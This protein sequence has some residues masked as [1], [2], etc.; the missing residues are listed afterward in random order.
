MS[1]PQ[2]RNHM[3]S[4]ISF[5]VKEVPTKQN[6]L[7]GIVEGTVSDG[8]ETITDFGV[9]DATSSNST[10]PGDILDKAKENVTDILLQREQ[11]VAPTPAQR[12]SFPSSTRQDKAKSNGG[13]TK[14]ASDKQI[15][16][17]ISKC[18]K[19]RH[20]PDDICQEFCGKPLDKLRGQDAH[21]IIQKLLH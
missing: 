11:S 17:I 13:G 19:L 18:K 3:H 16:M 6:G 12:Q 20:N 2:Q 10:Q 1:F 5:S 8:N 14:P 15:E 4:S 9:A 21:E 7:V